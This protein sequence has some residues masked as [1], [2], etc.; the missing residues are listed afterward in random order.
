LSSRK[1]LL[2]QASDPEYWKQLNPKLNIS[3]RSNNV[4]L[5]NLQ[6]EQG[7]ILQAK[8][9]L[10]TEGYFSLDDLF[11][12]VLMDEL[13]A[14]VKK[15]WETGWPTPF[16]VVYDEYWKLFRALAP[17]F[18]AILGSG[19]KQVPNFWCWYIDNKDSSK[20]WGLHR[21]RPSVNT[22]REDGQVSSLTVWIPL[23]DATVL[24][25][26]IYLLPAHLDPN[27]PHRLESFDLPD[28]ASLRAL[29]ASRGSVLAWSEAILHMGSR[30]SDR[31][32]N[33]RVSIS[34]TFQRGDLG[35]YESP[36]FDPMMLPSFEER[37]GL[38]S[39]NVVKYNNQG[40]FSRDILA[41]SSKLSVLIPPILVEDGFRHDILESDKPLSKTLLWRLQQEYFTR[42]N[43]AAWQTVPF[44]V[45]SRMPFAERY[46][47][48]FLAYLLDH[49]DVLKPEHELYI[50]ELGGGTGCFAYRFLNELIEK[51][52]G[53]EA[54]KRLKFR[55]VLTDFTPA[56]VDKWL[57]NKK[58]RQHRQAGILDFAVFRPEEDNK[59]QLLNSG[60]E[61]TGKD[62]KNP[63]TVIANYV[64]DSIPH[65]AF[66][67]DGGEIAEARFTLFRS[68][69]ER[70]LDVPVSIDQLTMTERYFN[71]EKKHYGDPTLDAILDYY[72][73]NL[74]EASVIFPIGAMR[75]IANLINLSNRELVLFASDKG[76]KGLESRQIQGLWPQRF[77]VHGSFSFDVNF[78]AIG[79]Y[80]EHHGGRSLTEAGAHSEL[81][82]S[83][84]ILSRNK[85]SDLD[86]LRHYFRSNLVKTHLVNSLFDIEELICK[87]LYPEQLERS[88]LTIFVSIVRAYNFEPVVF[89]IAF[90]RM[91]DRLEKELGRMDKE[92]KTEFLDLLKRVS[93]NLYMYDKKHDALDC[94]LRLYVWVKNFDE[95]LKLCQESLEAFGPL[96]TIFDHLAICYENMGRFDLANQYFQE[97][98]KLTPDHS[99]AQSGF[100]R[101]KNRIASL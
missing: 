95:C 54:L 79:R 27:F 26:C 18:N 88:W 100:E 52:E 78:D 40:K 99:W 1:L 33:P 57:D 53:F 87:A 45:T 80:F 48:M 93:R 51:I 85:K 76:F 75:V 68:G 5:E 98:L 41:V 55:Y 62:L 81:C 94:L 28:L 71:I 29:P 14:G 15:V 20:G 35:P 12:K 46:A 8:E 96:G 42:E 90:H 58:L 73:T 69:R 6:L 60:K 21:D 43:L 91:S 25:G 50:I 39:Q 32:S 44:Y 10:R 37:L 24:N 49:Q 23:T 56:I 65:D 7:L 72:R 17:L 59:L 82:T 86:H 9:R 34:Y 74:E 70:S 92:Q 2:D 83:I 66:R 16:V 4:A 89:T 61:L 77:S 31:A 19:Y 63:L 84:N 38:I 22:V 67:V 36:L 97:S 47:E 13:A 101:T 11:D 3:Q 64:F 30:S